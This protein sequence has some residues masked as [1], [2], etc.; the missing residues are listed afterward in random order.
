MAAAAR[1]LTAAA[2]TLLL[3]LVGC[4]RIAAPAGVYALSSNETDPQLIRIDSASG[5]VT[6]VGSQVG[7]D[8]QSAEALSTLDE[9]AGVLYALLYHRP[10]PYLIGLDLASGAVVANVSLVAE[11]MTRQFV[12]LGPVCRRDGRRPARRGRRHGRRLAFP[13]FAPSPTP[14]RL[15]G[16]RFLW[17]RRG[18]GC[19]AAALSVHQSNAGEPDI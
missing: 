2:A 9:E 18:G 12:G 7:M 1:A 17:R 11:F 6:R 19:G 8:W 16:N 13:F 3:L 4:A 10:G 5:T 14:A 15:R